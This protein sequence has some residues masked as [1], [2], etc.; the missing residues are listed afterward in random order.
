MLSTLLAANAF[1]PGGH[2]VRSVR[3]VMGTHAPAVTPLRVA[4]AM[5][6]DQPLAAGIGQLGT[7][8]PGPMSLVGERDACG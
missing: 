5:P 2:A 6:D 7:P 4:M 1:A 3:P 8:E